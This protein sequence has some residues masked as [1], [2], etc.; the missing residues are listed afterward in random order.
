MTDSTS[1]R[2][3]P[4]RARLRTKRPAWRLFDEKLKVH[5]AQYLRQTLMATV[6]MLVVLL[7]LD[8]VKQTVLIAS[9]G[10][11]TFIVFSRPHAKRSKPRYL[12]GGYAVGT[13]A[14]CALSVISA[15]LIEFS[16]ADPRIIQICCAAFALG[17]AF[18]IMVV[19]DTEHPP[20]AAL[21][22]G[23]VL[24]EWDLFALF[25]V[26]AGIA[27]ITSVKELIKP[28]LLDLI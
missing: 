11:S 19:T 3:E 21:A 10:A 1:G 15:R 22:L 7:L 14:G 12:I 26:L 18:L 2:Q 23:Y 8:V 24:N 25:V 17:L 6:T 27:L 13:L 28:K 9:L 5:R 16:F 20:A 4:K